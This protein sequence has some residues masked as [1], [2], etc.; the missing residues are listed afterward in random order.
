MIHRKALAALAMGVTAM[1]A[2]AQAISV[3]GL[4]PRMG[5][6]GRYRGCYH[7]IQPHG[8]T[9]G[10]AKPAHSGI[11]P[12]HRAASIRAKGPPRWGSGRTPHARIPP[13]LTLHYG[14]HIPTAH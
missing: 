9:N 11:P 4:H 5:G 6:T 2:Q 14:G 7:G 3:Y 10:G 8:A 1:G 13:A 12:G